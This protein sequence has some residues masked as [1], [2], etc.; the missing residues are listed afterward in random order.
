MSDQLE[1]ST[2]WDTELITW[3]KRGTS[4]LTRTVG[5]RESL[6]CEAVEDE[7]HQSS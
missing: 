3:S 7:D 5:D 1:R 2:D 6:D 4:I